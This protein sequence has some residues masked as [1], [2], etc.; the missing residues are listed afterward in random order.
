M[1]PPHLGPTVYN[2]LVEAL[3]HLFGDTSQFIWAIIQESQWQAKEGGCKARE[4]AYWKSLTADMEGEAQLAGLLEPID[5][6]PSPEKWAEIMDEFEEML[7]DSIVQN[8]KG[9]IDAKD[10]V[11][12]RGSFSKPQDKL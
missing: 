7:D 6:E 8:D 11:E 1:Q 12:G 5:G 9:R 2:Q 3:K 10:R 4:M